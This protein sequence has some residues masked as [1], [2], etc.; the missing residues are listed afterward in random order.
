VV[1][2]SVVVDF[3]VIVPA[4]AVG[5]VPNRTPLTFERQVPVMVTI[6][7]PPVGP[8]EVESN[9]T[10]GVQSNKNSNVLP[11]DFHFPFSVNHT[12]KVP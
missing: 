9:L 7:P 8:V 4:G 5:V 3:V 12:L 2:T 11:D 10:K 1:T 6:V